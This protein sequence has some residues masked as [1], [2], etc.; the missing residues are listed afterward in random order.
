MTI[1]EAAGGILTENRRLLDL[2]ELAEM[3]DNKYKNIS[4]ARDP[5]DSIKKTI[6]SNI[7]RGRTRGPKLIYIDT[8]KGKLVG[9]PEWQ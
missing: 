1:Q 8:P 5:L 6:H 2:M 9:L 7:M 3:V 4:N